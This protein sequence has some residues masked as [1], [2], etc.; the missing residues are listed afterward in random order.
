MLS[1]ETLLV[2]TVAAFVRFA[3]RPGW[4]KVQRWFLGG[5][6]GALAAWLALDR[7]TA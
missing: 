6:F 4:L 5:T 3:R 7:K 2:F 1:L